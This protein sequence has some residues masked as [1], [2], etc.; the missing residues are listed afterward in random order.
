LSFWKRSC[1]I[2]T[3]S[4]VEM[5]RTV[6]NSLGASNQVE[7]KFIA[8]AGN[9]ERPRW[10]AKR[11]ELRFRGEVILKFARSA[12]NEEPILDEF[13]RAGWEP[14]ITVRSVSLPGVKRKA[15]LQNAVK[16]LNRKQ[17]VKRIHFWSSG[18]GTFIAWSPIEHGPGRKQPRTVKGERKTRP[19]PPQ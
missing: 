5:A 12:P 2:L 4:G 16:E 13:E 10:D 14:R 9:S 19:R 17:R 6:C 11:L 15:R 1:F 7:G 3:D 8:A 18:A